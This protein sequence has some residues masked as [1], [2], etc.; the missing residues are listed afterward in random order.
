MIDQLKTE[1]IFIDIHAKDKKAVV[2]EK[3]HLRRLYTNPLGTPIFMMHGMV[4][5]GK[6]FYS[7]SN[8]GLAPYLAQ[9]G[10]DVFVA[11]NRGKGLCQ[12]PI[13]KSSKHGLKE[14]ITYDYDAYLEAIKDIK[15]EVPQHWIA[16][17]WG[18]VM[19]LAYLA[20]T[21]SLP[22]IAS[23]VMFGSKRRVQITSLLKLWRVS[24]LWDN[25]L[26]LVVK[27]KGYLPAVRLKVGAENES[28]KE[29]FQT[30]K[31]VKSK[32]WIDWNDSFDYSTAL[33]K[34]KLP[35]TL[36]LT[37]IRDKV[38][39]HPKDVLALIKEAGEEHAE[40]KVLGK[41]NGHLHNYGHVDILTHKD[42]PT[43][44]FPIALDFIKQN[45]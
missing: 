8:K 35:P 28:L 3:L 32:K 13:S 14:I 24:F 19:M 42:S 7:D 17:S 30:A 43:D 10:F 23:M 2:D 40:L 9:Q 38:L 34:L 18:G 44:V 21:K 6:I 1:S 4:E 41:K 29:Y 15:G 37:G 22:K 25:I 16:H 33:K 39:G 11:D 12:P 26:P 5:S 36:H 20:R 31:W 27:T 45:N